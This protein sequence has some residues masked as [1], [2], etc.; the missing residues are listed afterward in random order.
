MMA[1]STMRPA[2]KAIFLFLFLAVIMSLQV[3]GSG[4]DLNI[5]GMG[6]AMITLMKIAQVIGVIIIFILPAI[7]FAFLFFPEKLRIFGLHRM[8]KLRSLIIVFFL[9]LAALPLIN[10]LK[11]L[12]DMVKLPASMAGIEQWMQAS[13]KNMEKITEIFVSGTGIS[14]L[15]ANLF[16]IAF[17]AAI[18]EEV[19]FRGI[20]QNVLKENTRNIHTAILITAIVFSMVHLQFY[21]FLP[22]MMLGLL[23]GYLYYWSRTLWLPV[24]AHFVNN[25]SAVFFMWLE[26]RGQIPVDADRIGSGGEVSLV[27]GSLTT[28]LILIWLL[29]KSERESTIPVDNGHR[30]S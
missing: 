22:R 3:A 2:V 13:E 24:F 25:G 28:V 10:W 17:M 19:F 5:E 15:I 20:M 9:I 11:E 29:Y 18:S 12:N 30:N 16:I 8:P 27:I 4:K 6:D 14:D 23:L 21:G 26:K 1:S 7:G